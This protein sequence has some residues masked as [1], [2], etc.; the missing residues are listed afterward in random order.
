MKIYMENVML[1]NIVLL[2]EDKNFKGKKFQKLCNRSSELISKVMDVD[3]YDG[4]SAFGK[5]MLLTDAFVTT[6]RGVYQ[7]SRDIKNR[8]RIVSKVFSI[9][10]DQVT[11][12]FSTFISSDNCFPVYV[13]DFQYDASVSKSRLASLKMLFGDADLRKLHDF[14]YLDSLNVVMG[15]VYTSFATNS[16]G[17]SNLE[18]V[19]G[20]MHFENFDKVPN[21]EN[22]SYLGGHIYVG[23][24]VLSLD[25]VKSSNKEFVK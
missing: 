18:V 9:P 3:Y 22:L 16:D 10:K 1:D 20:D 23:D 24:S 25:E 14:Q 13:S 19:T 6:L 7:E 8:E 5:T 11:G 12:D 15:N 4:C 21:L 2:S 17:L